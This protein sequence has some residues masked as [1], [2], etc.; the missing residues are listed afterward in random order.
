MQRGPL[1]RDAFDQFREI[2][3][4]RAAMGRFCHREYVARKSGGWRYAR[5][6]TNQ[7]YVLKG[8]Q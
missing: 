5:T 6:I 8:T 7:S 3:G 2:Q 1:P 4:S